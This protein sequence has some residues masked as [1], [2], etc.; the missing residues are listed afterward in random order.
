MVDRLEERGLAERRRDPADRRRQAVTRTPDGERTFEEAAAPLMRAED[1]Y[2]APLDATE[3]EPLRLL[4]R[5]L[6]LSR[7][8]DC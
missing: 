8:P 1:D 3:R 2:L 6:Y 4:L 5:R 7:T